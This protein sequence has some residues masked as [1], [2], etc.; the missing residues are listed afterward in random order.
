M[1]DAEGRDAIMTKRD[2]RRKA[3]ALL[4]H[5]FVGAVDTLRHSSIS[6]LLREAPALQ[7]NEWGDTLS[8]KEKRY[9]L[10]RSQHI[11]RMCK[12]VR[13]LAWKLQGSKTRR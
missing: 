13:N 8:E 7:S 11:D 9:L 10:Q 1:K 5:G 12:D 2:V 6:A 3:A 4:L